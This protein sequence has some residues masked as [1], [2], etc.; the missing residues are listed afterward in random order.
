[1][2]GSARR[3]WGAT[4]RALVFLTSAEERGDADRTCA[5]TK[6]LEW[7]HA[8]RSAGMLQ[9][10][11]GELIVFVIRAPTRCHYSSILKELIMTTSSFVGGGS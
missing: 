1:M 5:R 10:L 4:V 7:R 9:F 8:A 11:T 6:R 3:W 2:V